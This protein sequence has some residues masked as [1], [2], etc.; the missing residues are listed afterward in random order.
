MNPDE[1]LRH[2]TEE[3][4]ADLALGEEVGADVT[5]HLTACVACA[6]E[7]AELRRVLTLA[8]GSGDVELVAP[9]AGMWESVAR[10]ADLASAVT[11]VPRAEPAVDVERVAEQPPAEVVRLPRRG[12]PAW[13]AATAA[14]VAL[15]AGVGLG[16]LAFDDPQDAPPAPTVLSSAA[17]ATLDASAQGRGTAEVRREDDRVVLHVAATD[18]D[19]PEGI[20]EVWLINTDGT[21]MVSLGLL[22]S[23]ESGDFEFPERLLDQGYLI[24]DISSEPDDGN[25]T[26]SGTS[27]ARGT[28]EA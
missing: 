7:V 25:P 8:R 10:E 4:F 12:V 6:T 2:P 5:D 3:T 9:P 24:V 18:L 26:H 27:L 16:A 14:A 22:S 23:G 15:V 21:R 1:T 19:G 17:L 20:R 28:L 11:D 13:L